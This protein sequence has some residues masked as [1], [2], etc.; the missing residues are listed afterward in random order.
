M[1][2]LKNKNQRITVRKSLKMARHDRVK[3]GY[4]PINM[5]KPKL[6]D[7]PTLRWT[8]Q[9]IADSAHPSRY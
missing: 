9:E 3:A 7:V 5:R 2:R 1:S 4:P 8:K 6:G